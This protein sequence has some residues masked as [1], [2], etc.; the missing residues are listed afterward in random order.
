MIAPIVVWFWTEIIMRPSTSC[1]GGCK[2]FG[3]NRM[4]VGLHTLKPRRLG[5][6]SSHCGMIQ[7]QGHYNWHCMRD[8][9][10]VVHILNH[11]ELIPD[12]FGS[13]R[14][15]MCRYRASRDDEGFVT[16]YSEAMPSSYT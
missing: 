10:A 5:P 2:A 11:E 3:C 9:I 14:R 12:F 8:T 13:G 7:S 15:L 6:G 1:D 4:S 16:R